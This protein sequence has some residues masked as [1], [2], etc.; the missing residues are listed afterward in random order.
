MNKIF[1][2]GFVVLLI[3]MAVCMCG[4]VISEF[5]LGRA[6]FGQLLGYIA[7]VAF[8]MISIYGLGGVIL[9][10]ILS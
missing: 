10:D 1:A 8:I 2:V 4:A 6:Q 3:V 5:L 7:V 9:L